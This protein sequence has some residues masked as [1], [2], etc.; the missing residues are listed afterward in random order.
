MDLKVDINCP[1]CESA[2]TVTMRDVAN[3]R[4]VRC[5]RGHAITLVDEGRGARQAQRSM[6]DLDKALK[7]LGKRR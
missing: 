1:E 5:P 2:L 7:N 3:G 6:D 4:T